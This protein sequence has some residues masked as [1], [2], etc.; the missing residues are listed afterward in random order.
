MAACF[1]GGIAHADLGALSCLLPMGGTWLA[2]ASLAPLERRGVESFGERDAV[3]VTFV[4]GLGLP[5]PALGP[6]RGTYTPDRRRANGARFAC[7]TGCGE[8]F[9]VAHGAA[10]LPHGR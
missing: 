3:R 10:R 2:S 8:Q 4:V 1:C 6:L 7:R 5:F 9:L